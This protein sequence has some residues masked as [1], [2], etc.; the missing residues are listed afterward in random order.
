MF[1]IR[2]SPLDGSG[3]HGGDPAR[4]SWCRVRSDYLSGQSE[5]CPQGMEHIA[6]LLHVQ[7]HMPV[8]R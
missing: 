6:A 7:N 4:Y 1:H 8:E 5:M 3:S 2:R